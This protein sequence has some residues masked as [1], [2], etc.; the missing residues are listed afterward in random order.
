PNVGMPPRR[1]PLDTVR[2]GAAGARP[3]SLRATPTPW[4]KSP[5]S[6]TSPRSRA[7][8]PLQIRPRAIASP[9]SGLMSRPLATWPTNLQRGR[10]MRFLGA[11]VL[12]P[13]LLMLGVAV[14]VLYVRADGVAPALQTYWL[15]IHVSVA[16]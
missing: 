8:R 16:T 2:T 9:C 10:D 7:S 1:K 11:F 3:A 12:G 6:S 4:W 5:S 14:S 15:I 13:V